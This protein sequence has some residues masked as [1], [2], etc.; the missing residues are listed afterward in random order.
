MGT[1]V[2]SEQIICKMPPVLIERIKNRARQDGSNMSEFVRSA[3]REKLA[4]DKT[5][6]EA[7]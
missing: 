4:T 6:R 2:Y 7:C 3:I 5:L 1:T